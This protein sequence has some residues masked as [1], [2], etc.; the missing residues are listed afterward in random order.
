VKRK[1]RSLKQGGTNNGKLESQPMPMTITE[2]LKKRRKKQKGG[3]EDDDDDE[4]RS[5]RWLKGRE[6]VAPRVL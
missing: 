1:L 3:S 2:V 4:R 5:T 6:N